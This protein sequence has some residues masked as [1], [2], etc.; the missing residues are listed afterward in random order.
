MKPVF[1]IGAGRSGT[2]MLYKLLCLN[3]DFAWISNYMVKFPGINSIAAINR[4][5]SHNTDL[6][7]QSWFSKESNAFY[8]NRKLIKKIVPTPV[9][10]EVIYNK[11]GFLTYPSEDWVLDEKTKHNII[12]L[13]EGIAKYQAKDH[14]LLKRTANNRRIKQILECFPDAR[15]INITR[16][17]RAVAVSLTRVNWWD[18]H[19]IWWMNQKTPLELVEENHSNIELAASNWVEE[20]KCIESGIKLIPPENLLTIKYED[21][22]S[23]PEEYLV[24]CAHHAGVREHEEWLNAVRKLN[25]YNSSNAWKKHLS[26]QE[27]ES[28]TNIQSQKLQ[29]LGYA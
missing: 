22:A 21:F 29:E 25:I 2:T 19:K 3:R 9:E 27:Q 18:N 26:L 12:G 14:L 16:D 6:K 1:I 7:V 28:V 20:L 4:F 10:G 23:S 24:K 17:G 5:T 8:S 11:G 13:F 15:F